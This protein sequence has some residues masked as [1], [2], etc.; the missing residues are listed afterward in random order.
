MKIRYIAAM[1]AGMVMLA[2]CSV[3]QKPQ[4]TAKLPIID[5]KETVT[6]PVVKQDTV[7]SRAE[8]PT[9]S[10]TAP[11]QPVHPPVAAITMQTALARNL[12]G[13]WQ[14]IQVG[15]T[16]IDRDEDMPYL[17][18][19]PS[20]AQFY[21]NNGCNTLNGA[22]AVTDKDEITFYN[23]LSTMR[24]CPDTPFDNQ[25]N[26]I[27]ADGVTTRLK[28][29]EIGQET[30]VDFLGEG[31]KSIM[32]MRRGNLDFLNGNWDVVSITG[33]KKLEVPADIFFD[34][35]E[36][37][38]HGNTGCNFVNGDIYLDHRRPGAVDFSN[39]AT[40]RMACPYTDQQTAMLVNL[41]E[42]TTAISDGQ[43]K[44]MLLNADGKPLMTLRRAEPNKE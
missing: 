13:E 24:L 3:L 10:A 12:G 38:L 43:D 19:E 4:K 32:R 26:T 16:T 44:V 36:L 33:L 8:E 7:L 37:K 5:K 14:I 42:A 1:V 27:V 31:G 17:I 35:K 25:I 39:M 21:G 30:F 2:S 34:L 6:T 41:E 29:T 40:T 22:Y 15:P 28:M 9:A 11:V 18:F 23:V 20:S